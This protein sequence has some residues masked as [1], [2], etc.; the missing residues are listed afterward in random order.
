MG[1]IAK[2][3]GKKWNEVTDSTKSIYEAKAAE[4]KIRYEA[5]SIHFIIIV[6]GTC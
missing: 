6:I 4:D 5:V 2:E 3:L 1:D